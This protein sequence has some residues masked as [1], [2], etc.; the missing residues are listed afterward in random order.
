MACRVAESC[1]HGAPREARR[2]TGRR[3]AAAYNRELAD[4]F[5][6]ERTTIQLE[7]E[8]GRCGQASK[9]VV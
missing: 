7:V 4:R 8:D 3:A 2:G 6:I 1:A 5:G 9:H